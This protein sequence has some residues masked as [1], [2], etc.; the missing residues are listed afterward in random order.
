MNRKERESVVRV[1]ISCNSNFE[2]KN[3]VSK[4][5]SKTCRDHYVNEQKMKNAIDGEDYVVCNWCGRK[6]QR[7]FGQHMLSHPGKTLD[8][9]KL[10]FPNAPV[11]CTKDIASFSKSS[12]LHMKL[13]VYKQMA[14]DKLKGEKNHNHKSNT[15]L[16]QRQAIS[17]FS[18]K[19]YDK[20]TTLS[21][22]QKKVLKS[23]FVK[24][25]L[26]NRVLTQHIEYWTRR[27]LSIDDAKL[28]VIDRQQTFT[29]E[30]L[31]KKHGAIEAHNIWDKRQASWKS[32]VFNANTHISS[33]KS[34]VANCFF[35]DLTDMISAKNYSIMQG[36][37]ERFIRTDNYCYKYDFCIKEIRC[38]IEFNGTYWHCKPD[39]YDA[40]YYHKIKKMTAPEIWDFDNL[41]RQTAEKYGYNLLT[42]WEDNYY[43]DPESQLKK[44]Q[45][46]I[47]DCSKIHNSE[48]DSV[49]R[50]DSVQ[51]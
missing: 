50:V 27:G 17:P 30:K 5:C 41:K 31:I 24:S 45:D 9:Y 51:K 36:A 20:H 42:I 4:F 35:K 12:G 1:C 2:T 21:E 39:L 7:I 44:A 15:T 6:C 32:K 49:H 14:S 47:N 26:K 22:D 28:A 48:N 43:R 18:D 34:I 29:I 25:A 10:E 11:T 8:D 16:E 37:N 23:A 3:K 13:D 33:S 46:F 40:S 19:F 38:I